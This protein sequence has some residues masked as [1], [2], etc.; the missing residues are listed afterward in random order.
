MNWFR[1]RRNERELDEEFAFHIEARTRQLED[2]GMDHATAERTARR[3]LDGIDRHKEACRDL[4]GPSEYFD[5]A[6]RAVR[7]G[8]RRLAASP[9]FTITAVATLAIGIGAATAVFSLINGIFLQPLPYRE[10][11]QLAAITQNVIVGDRRHEG[12]PVSVTHWDQ[13]RKHAKS[14]D[15][16]ALINGD[17]RY[18][19]GAPVTQ[20]NVSV[21]FFEMLGVTPFLGRSFAPGEDT[22]GKD[23]ITIL[24]FAF[25]RDRFHSDPGVLGRELQLNG[26][27]SPLIVGV[28]PEH[29]DFLRGNDLN[30]KYPLPGR[31]D[32]WR[33]LPVDTSRFNPLTEFNFLVIARFKP[34]VSVRLG[35]DE[36]TR[37]SQGLVKDQAVVTANAAAL[38]AAIWGGVR[39]PLL[40]LSAA[41]GAVLLI[42]CLN[43]A[44]LML[45]RHLGRWREYA[46]RASLGA[47][48]GRLIIEMVSEGAMLAMLG[49]AAGLAGA[50]ALI[51]ALP[52]WT[53]IPLPSSAVLAFDWRVAC[54]AFAVCAAAAVLASIFPALRFSLASPQDAMRT[55]GSSRTVAGSRAAGRMR[56][57]LVAAEVSLCVVLLVAAGLLIRSLDSLMRVDSG[58]NASQAVT[59]NVQLPVDLYKTPEQRLAAWRRVTEKLSSI[60]GVTAVGTM[61]RLPMSSENNVNGVLAEGEPPR[62]ILDQPLA[63]YRVATAGYFPAAGVRLLSGRLYTDADTDR[64]AVVISDN[65]AQRVWPGVDP[66]GRRFRRNGEGEWFTVVGVVAGVRQSSLEAAPSMMVY[67]G[68]RGTGGLSVVVRTAMTP[69]AAAAAVR[70]AINSVDRAIMMDEVRSMADLVAATT[71]KRRVQTILIGLFAA[72]AVLLAGLGIWGVVSYTAGQRRNEIGVRMALGA[73]PASA[74]ALVLRQGLRPVAIG[75]LTGIALAIAATRF[76]ESL[77]FGVRPMDT[78][79]YLASGAVLLVIAVAASAIPARAAARVDPMQS[80]RAE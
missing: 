66:V 33:P 51:R 64:A 18:F 75:A 8:A 58:F 59:V 72:V 42:C 5:R 26:G 57:A 54:F 12:V 46:V 36:L 29:F 67:R 62:A 40:L 80:L 31:A 24:S 28:L 35:E 48:R 79:T 71:A 49:G 23:G 20:T 44:N 11:D 73:T 37:I 45:A 39:Q 43:V 27:E 61:N 70:E 60:P 69:G 14:L 10:P 65:L 76:I 15:A 63:N 77:L 50:L 78:V 19:D 17:R 25:W 13:W 7:H 41:I 32:F 56:S 38:P 74:A 53:S 30:L 34:G 55:G 2:A 1:R 16:A 52:G 4:R 68:E 9:G 47:S 3:E 21:G 6:M 22:P